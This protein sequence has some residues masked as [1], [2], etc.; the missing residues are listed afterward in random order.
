MI[1][2]QHGRYGKKSGDFSAVLQVSV[3]NSSRLFNID[4]TDDHNTEPEELS[5][6]ENT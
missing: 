4:S 2:A 1:K 3:G 6:I 5:Y